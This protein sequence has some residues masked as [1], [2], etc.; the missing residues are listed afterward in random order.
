MQML[1]VVDGRALTVFKWVITP[2]NRG[3]AITRFVP[4]NTKSSHTRTKLSDNEILKYLPLA[5]V[6][7]I[8]LFS[9]NL[10]MSAL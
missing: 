2:Q 9:G 8:I 5:L 6:Y 10:T 4:C 1:M 7:K 3:A